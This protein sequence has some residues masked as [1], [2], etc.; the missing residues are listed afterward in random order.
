M[1]QKPVLWAGVYARALRESNVKR[2]E[3]WV[4]APRVR[5]WALQGPPCS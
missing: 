5:P 1:A 2:A 3:V 4:F